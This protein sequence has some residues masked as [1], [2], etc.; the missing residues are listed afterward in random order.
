MARQ[1]AIPGIIVNRVEAR[2]PSDG[3][4]LDFD[5]K[6]EDVTFDR[7][8]SL[9]EQVNLFVANT[10]ASRVIYDLDVAAY[11]KTSAK[12][13]A[14]AFVRLKNPFEV[15]IVNTSRP[16]KVEDLGPVNG[17]RNAYTVI[18]EIVK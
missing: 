6:P 18:V 13:K 15:D 10:G 16:R 14:R 17:F 3:K 2:T 9:F 5:G 11:N 4:A 8:R 12:S 7:L 1:T